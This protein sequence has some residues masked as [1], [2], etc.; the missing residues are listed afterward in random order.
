MKDKTIKYI[1]GDLVSQESPKIKPRIRDK[2]NLGYFDNKKENNKAD[3]PKKDSNV[4]ARAMRSKKKEKGR[5][6]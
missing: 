5:R 4:S 3:R 6:Q 2:S 1:A